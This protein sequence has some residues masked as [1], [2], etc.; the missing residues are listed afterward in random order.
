V[1]ESFFSIPF[2]LVLWD[3]VKDLHT[4]QPDLLPVADWDGVLMIACVH[5]PS[6][7]QM[8]SPHRFVLASPQHLRVIWNK[9]NPEHKHQEPKAEAPIKSA[10][11]AREP[12]AEIPAAESFPSSHVPEDSVVAD[13]GAPIEA[14]EMPEGFSTAAMG[15]A[16][17]MPEG[18]AMSLKDLA[19]EPSPDS[20]QEAMPAAEA[21][22]EAAPAAATELPDG[23]SIDASAGLLA[24]LTFGTP[25]KK[26]A[27]PTPVEASAPVEA[28]APLEAP[29]PVAAP[30]PVVA[31]A[32]TPAS[33]PAPSPAAETATAPFE[34][35]DEN[36]TMTNWDRGVIDTVDSSTPLQ[37][38]SSKEEVAQQTIQLAMKA[39]EGVMIFL[40][41]DGKPTPFRWTNHFSK[42][43]GDHAFGGADLSTPSIFRIV[44]R[45][46]LPYH[47]R[48]APS[49]EN[50]RF[51]KTFCGGAYPKNVTLMPVFH[52][53]EL[54]GM[55]LGIST[56]TLSYKTT[57][58]Y[59]ERVG[60]DM[61]AAVARVQS[62][63]AA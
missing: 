42:Q 15:G 18:L 63:K 32:P 35:E 8:S 5:P 20:F 56:Q 57:L 10:A 12:V 54:L 49:P 16:D 40:I 22:A 34:A 39:F 38:C 14:F 47:G 25:K 48:I 7:F 55:I 3:R 59:L 50:D 61:A 37:N 13:L 31:A 9:A 19:P 44:N 41:K 43:G 33:Q 36:F 1:K 53:K 62:K 2:D 27:E 60:R 46:R 23:I 45:S 24:K 11:P 58:P 6:D 29:A 4:W 51:F 28:P 21:A 17:E 26:P 52:E 30:T